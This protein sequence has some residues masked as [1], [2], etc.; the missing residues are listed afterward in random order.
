LDWLWLLKLYVKTIYFIFL[1]WYE[2]SGFTALQLSQHTC[3]P[4][5][6][7]HSVALTLASKSV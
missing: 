6:S 2:Q 7:W 4:K 1:F 3:R 5:V